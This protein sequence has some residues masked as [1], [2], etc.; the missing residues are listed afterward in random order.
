MGTR[1]TALAVCVN[2]RRHSFQNE[3]GVL[4]SEW[5]RLRV[6]GSQQQQRQLSGRSPTLGRGPAVPW[7]PGA[8]A[9]SWP[10]QTATSR[11]RPVVTPGRWR[12]RRGE[13][14]RRLFEHV[15]AWK[16]ESGHAL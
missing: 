12:T 16:P 13:A 3:S 15:P 4:Y 10:R 9:C 8:G 6:H 2:A 11:M 5:V 1:P 14:Q 7:A